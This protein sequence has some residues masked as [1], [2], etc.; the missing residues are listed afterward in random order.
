MIAYANAKINIGLNI[1]GKRA[2]GYHEIE[3]VFYPFDWYDILEITEKKEGEVSLEISGI[4]LP[5]DANNLCLK[6][7]RLVKQHHDLPPVHIH[8]HKQIPFG[9]GLGGGSSD[10]AMVLKMLNEKYRLNLPLTTLATYAGKLGADC[11]FF[12]HNVPAYAT[13]IGTDLLPLDLN[14]EE[15]NLVLVK[16]AIHIST[17]E[18]YRQ[19]VPSVPETS[20]REL[21]KLPVQE[22]KY[23]IRNDFED[24]VFEQHPAI[25]EL[26]L[27]MYAEG[28]IYASMSGS[29]SA[30]F[31]IFD[32]N[33]D[34]D[35]LKVLGDVY[36]PVKL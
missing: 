14:L 13:G 2:D 30:V 19:V 1:T 5:V 16:P 29:G 15:Y 6:A 31:G 22:W 20:L 9:A 32:S 21:I 28:A 23:H 8:L 4:N 27:V 34:I 17:A 26:K 24:G 25:Q 3:T 33:M 18:A 35:D 10:A 36:H 12:I 11:P 7:Y